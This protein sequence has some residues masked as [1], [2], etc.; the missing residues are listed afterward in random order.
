M[1]QELIINAWFWHYVMPLGPGALMPGL[2]QRHIYGFTCVCHVYVTLM[3]VFKTVGFRIRHATVDADILELI[4]SI[5]LKA[6]EI[7]IVH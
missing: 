6:E 4:S 5:M 7:S 3:Q 1:V 2:S